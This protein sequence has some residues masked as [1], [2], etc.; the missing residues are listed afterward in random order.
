MLCNFHPPYSLPHP[1]PYTCRLLFCCV[2]T[3]VL[4]ALV[5]AGSWW[6]WL[7]HNVRVSVSHWRDMS[8]HCCTVTGVILSC[9]VSSTE[10]LMYVMVDNC[11]DKSLVTESEC[12]SVQSDVWSNSGAVSAPPPSTARPSDPVNS[13]WSWDSTSEWDSGLGTRGHGGIVTSHNL[14]PAVPLLY[15]GETVRRDS[16]TRDWDRQPQPLTGEICR[17]SGPRA[18]TRG[19]GSG[20]AY[21]GH[22]GPWYIQLLVSIGNQWSKVSPKIEK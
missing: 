13:Q 21:T 12:V 5:R 4:R 6:R 3:E 9:S 18:S 19:R 14:T 2:T 10:S 16:C 20:G 7:R 11:N 8:L 17:R 1:R 15:G 22:P